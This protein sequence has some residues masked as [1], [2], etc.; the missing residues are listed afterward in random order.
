MS[1]HPL[2]LCVLG[3]QS[4][5]QGT[6]MALV[7]N[8]NTW[9]GWMPRDP[10]TRV[11][12]CASVHVCVLPT[13]PG[14]P[15]A[16]ALLLLLLLQ[17]TAPAALGHH[18]FLDH[19]DDFV[20][21]AQVLDG[22]APNVALGHPPELVPV[23]CQRRVSDLWWSLWGGYTWPGR[24]QDACTWHH[25]CTLP[26][27]QSQI[28]CMEELPPSRVLK[29]TQHPRHRRKGSRVLGEMASLAWLVLQ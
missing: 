16:S 14:T 7:K 22:A 6:V 25:P 13:S 21:D 29:D 10:A 18:L 12:A 2:A 1:H 28:R 20:G 24:S 3:A 17:A 19:V 11:C 26:T 5:A 9:L 15:H 27:S 8:V 4:Q 23:L